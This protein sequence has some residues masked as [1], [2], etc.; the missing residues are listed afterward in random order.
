MHGIQLRIASRAAELLK[1]GGLMV[2]STCSLN[3]VENEAVVATLLLKFKDQLELV[4]SKDKLPTLKS[5]PGLHK[6]NLMT[7]QGD[8]INK[9]EEVANDSKLVNLLRPNMFPPEESVARELCLERCMR[10]LPHYQNSGGFFIAVIRKKVTP[11]KV[12]EKKDINVEENKMV[13]SDDHKPVEAD[14][15]RKMKA[16]PAKRVK[17]VWEENPFKFIDTNEVLM[18]D[19]PKIK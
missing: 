8:I 14:E 11:E 1:P 13:L 4:D 6:W 19:W 16:P 5:L 17:H 3:P 15:S 18:R 2:Y 12:V 9:V 7:K 10:I